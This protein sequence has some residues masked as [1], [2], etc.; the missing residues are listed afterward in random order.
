MIPPCLIHKVF[1]YWKFFE[2]QKGSPPKFFDTVRQKTFNRKSWYTTLMRKFFRY[3][4]LVK[5][6]RA[7]LRNFFGAVR[8]KNF[9]RKSWYTPDVHYLKNL[10]VLIIFFFHS[11]LHFSIIHKNLHLF[12]IKMSFFETSKIRYYWCQQSAFWK[13]GVWS[14]ES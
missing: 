7:P 11:F 2:T 12:K 14:E 1:R 3:P 5:H 9:D 4:K 8:W 6:R 13:C 10:S